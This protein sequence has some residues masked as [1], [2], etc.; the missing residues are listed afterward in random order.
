MVKAPKKGGKRERPAPSPDLKVKY[1]EQR[2]GFD[3]ADARADRGD[4]RINKFGRKDTPEARAIALHWLR[5]GYSKS[6][7]GGKAGVHADSIR[8][9][10]NKDDAFK[11]SVADAIDAGTDYL[12]DEAR[13][14]AADGVDRPIFQSGELVGFE[15]NYS[16]SLMAMQLQGRRP[17]RYNKT[18]VE[19]TGAEGGPIRVQVE[20][21]FVTGGDKK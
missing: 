12:E 17:E 3:E 21:E 7:A 5:L 16:D 14:R 20:V 6:F 9:W 11:A 2:A 13:R 15:R 19:H 8:D 18:K 1:D 4:H 10:M